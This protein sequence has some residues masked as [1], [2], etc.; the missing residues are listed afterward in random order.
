MKL[1][2]DALFIPQKENTKYN[3]CLNISAPPFSPSRYSFDI[4][5]NEESAVNLCLPPIIPAT[6]SREGQSDKSA[7]SMLQ[8][9]R[10]KNW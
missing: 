5:A 7:Y 3:F 9:M 2:P 8:N 6:N 10:V 4:S 1:N